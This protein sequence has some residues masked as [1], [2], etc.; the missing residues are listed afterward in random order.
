[1]YLTCVS[2]KLCKFIVYSMISF[3]LF[4]HFALF[5][6][7]LTGPDVRWW[8]SITYSPECFSF[9]PTFLVVFVCIPYL[10]WCPV[11]ALYHIFTCA[12]S[13]STEITNKILCCSLYLCN[14]LL[15]S[16]LEFEENELAR[17]DTWIP[18]KLLCC[19]LYIPVILSWATTS[20][21][22]RLRMIKETCWNSNNAI[23][24]SHKSLLFG[25][26]K[27]RMFYI[28]RENSPMHPLALF[29]KRSYIALC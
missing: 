17:P 28:Q 1:M 29:R 18:T 25:H 20:P 10:I 15:I 27:A 2:S 8:L 14:Y 6:L 22:T 4:S 5:C 7:I 12:L 11:V 3:F 16:T 9:F 24:T 23:I 13:L 19:S 26:C 21:D